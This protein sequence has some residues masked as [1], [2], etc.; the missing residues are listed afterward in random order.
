M[1]VENKKK[2]A[3]L[4]GV[5]N[6]A[7][8]L[9]QQVESIVAQTNR[10]WTLFVRDDGSADLSVDMIDKLCLANKNIIRI[11]DDKGN[12]GSKNNFFE[13]LQNVDSKYYMFCDQD[14]FWLPTKI[15]LTLRKMEEVELSFPMKPIIIHTD[16]VVADENLMEL[17]P[18]F[19][20]YS[21]ISPNLI[22]SFELLAVYNLITGCTMMFN[23]FGK[24]ASY[25]LGEKAE[26]HDVWISLKVSNAGGIID[27]IPDKTLLYRQHK[28]NVIGAKKIGAFSYFLDKWRNIGKIIIDNN[29]RLGMVR[30]VRTFSDIK[31]I[32]YKA[33]YFLRR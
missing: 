25:P 23:S 15:E 20:K 14:D 19:W 28:S 18:S 26:M 30:E 17:A 13:L 12:L 24:K 32:F 10:D 3:I 33:L 29:S 8:Y 1:E 27:F 2:I 7:V 21:K 9:K 22:N 4:L 31:Y 6:G 11:K 16:L 5:Y